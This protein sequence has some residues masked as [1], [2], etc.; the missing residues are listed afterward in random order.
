MAAGVGY[1]VDPLVEDPIN[2]G[3]SSFVFEMTDYVG[4][5][6]PNATSNWFSDWLLMDVEG[7]NCPLVSNP[8]QADNDFDGRGDACDR[9]TI[10][11]VST[12]STTR[13]RLMTQR[14]KIP[15]VT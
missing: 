5:V 1:L 7:D 15:M 10:M 13:S 12:T 11:M 9:M 6:D 8:D 3:G 4:A 2:A 14:V